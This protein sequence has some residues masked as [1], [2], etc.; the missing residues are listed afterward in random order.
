MDPVV[1]DQFYVMR[2]GRSRI[3]LSFKFRL[4]F[5]HRGLKERTIQPRCIERL[6][7]AADCI[8][9]RLVFVLQSSPLA[10]SFALLT[11]DNRGAEGL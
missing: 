4:S 5:Q 7:C 3:A 11:A 9:S 1:F 8:D 10:A 6:R 2:A